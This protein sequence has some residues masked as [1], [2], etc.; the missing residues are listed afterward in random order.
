M[1]ITEELLNEPQVNCSS[2]SEIWK[3]IGKAQAHLQTQQVAVEFYRTAR[4]LE[5]FRPELNNIGFCQWIE[6]NL[7]SNSNSS[8]SS[9]ASVAAEMAACSTSVV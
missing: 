3:L 2:P 1:Q 7:M 4:S 6:C 8:N 5:L 9:I